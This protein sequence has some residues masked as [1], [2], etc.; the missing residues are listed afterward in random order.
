MRTASRSVF[1]ALA[2]AV[3]A[4]AL[5]GGPLIV[6]GVTR[7]AWRY[8]PGNPLPVYTDVGNYSFQ[9][10]VW[11]DPPV[12]YV[13]DNAV[14]VAQVTK[15][16]AEWSG[17]P[18]SSF[19]ASVAGDFTAL[20]LPDITGANADLVIGAWNGGGVQVIFDADGTVFSEFF[21]V[22]P[23]VLGIS[24]PE[25]GDETTS[26]I[27]ESWTLLNGQA[28]YTDD[29]D[30]AHYQGVVTH[31][32]GHAIGLAHTQVNGAAALYGPWV[33]EPVGPQSCTTL[34]YRTDVTQRDVETMYPY[35][36]PAPWSEVGLAQAVIHTADDRAALSDLYPGPGWPA[37]TGTITGKVLGLDGRTE[38]TG[39]N[40]I[41]R[42][43]DDPFSDANSSL[44]GQWTQGQFGPDGSYTLNGLKPG[45]RYVVYVDAIVAGGFP[46]P[47]MW[48]LPGS[49]RFWNGS[50]KR[51]ERQPFDPCAYQVIVPRA[52]R[53]VRADLVFERR[54]GAPVVQSL[55]YGAFVTGMTGDGKVAVGNYGL[56][57]P[58]FRWTEKTGVVSLGVTST[59]ETT[60]ISRNGKYISTNVFDPDAFADLGTWRWD[61]RNGWLLVDG[62]GDC[63]GSTTANFGV[64]NDGA[65]YGLTYNTCTDYKGFRWSPGRGTTVLPSAGLNPDGGPANG[66]PTQ[67]SADGTTLA[68]WEE[69]GWGGRV[70]TI[71]VNGKASRVTQADGSDLDE[72]M[73][74]SGDGKVVSGGTYWGLPNE[75]LGWR[76]RVGRSAGEIEYYESFS[77][78]ATPP[79]AY[80]MNRDGSVMA[81][82]AGNPWFSFVRGPFI[83]TKQ[84]GAVDLDA[85]LRR[86]G[87]SFD[88]YVTLRTPTAMSDD[89]SVIGGWGEGFQYYAGWV[90]QMPNVF[91][92]HLERGERGSGRTISV[93]FPKGLDEHLRHGDADGPCPGHVD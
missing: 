73:S 57:G 33:G 55:E 3:A 25:W 1:L 16:L 56:G 77:P 50:G 74:V 26:F 43:L 32:F 13:F 19:R 75:G 15:A 65:V 23:Y 86:Q 28:I 10:D 17:V 31:E 45:A 40:V 64:A 24:S 92:C 37:A 85:F 58:A 4:P 44:S 91:V 14:G 21:G 79:T 11:S 80:T 22:S 63:G 42:N 87:S 68:G 2:L 9:V 46:T 27:T 34:P 49:E 89:G 5:A 62:T 48:F 41:A 72:A 61:E 7:K 35:S 76:K 93:E 70:A 53:P 39:V 82:Y 54:K 52:G 6:D 38:L 69:L 51:D 8:Q 29:V 71:W 30:A 83:W 88:Q 18:T 90:V 66:R 36:D 84:M 47:P 60:S 78:E 20:G 67:I 81:G 59:G 12:E